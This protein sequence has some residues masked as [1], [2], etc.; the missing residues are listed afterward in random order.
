M[1]HIGLHHVHGR[2]VSA[3]RALPDSH[4]QIFPAAP[5]AP[6]TILFGLSP[7]TPR[8]DTSRN[9]SVSLPCRIFHQLGDSLPL[10]R[11]TKKQHVRNIH[12]IPR[13]PA[14]PDV[15][16][17]T[18]RRHLLQSHAARPRHAGLHSGCRHHRRLLTDSSH[19]VERKNRRQIQRLYCRL[20]NTRQNSSSPH[21]QRPALCK[22]IKPHQSC[23]TIILIQQQKHKQVRRA[24]IPLA[25]RIYS[26]IRPY[27]SG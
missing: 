6:H 11:H 26:I 22:T 27:S 10:L 17:R 13:L 3:R 4:Y 8:N 21:T 23:N 14:R 12:G 7:R 24:Q 5:T 20:K 2:A 19:S 16:T 25:D 18:H 15:R 9:H 1:R